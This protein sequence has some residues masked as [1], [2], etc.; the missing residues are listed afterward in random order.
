VIIR[1]DL[2]YTVIFLNDKKYLASPTVLGEFGREVRV[3]IPG[4]MRVLV[5]AMAPNQD[6][7]FFTSKTPAARA[8]DITI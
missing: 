4:E 8:G 2:V 5:L 7:R 1:P 6:G 3:E